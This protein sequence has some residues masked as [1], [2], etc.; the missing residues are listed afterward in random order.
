MR[1]TDRGGRRGEE[2]GG[3]ER[4]G[5]QMSV[6]CGSCGPSSLRKMHVFHY[7]SIFGGRGR[8][9]V[10][11]AGRGCVCRYATVNCHAGG[12]NI[13]LRITL[14][15]INGTQGEGNWSHA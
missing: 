2:K 13:T 6:L 12:V 5:E 8:L 15:D 3:E 1:R 7:F 9:C 11:L 14:Q 4:R 10:R